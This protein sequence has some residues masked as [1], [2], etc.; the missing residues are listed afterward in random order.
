[1]EST[2]SLPILTPIE[3]RVLG[4]LIEKSK[5]TPD[6]YPMTLN[7]LTAACNQK[8]SRRPV[9]DYDEETVV[10]ALNSLKSQSLINTAVGGSIRSIKYKHNFTIV[11]PLTDGEL[12]IMCLLFLRGPQTPGELNTNS[13]R[14]HEFRSLEGLQDALNKLTEG[15][16]AFVKELPKRAGQKEARFAHLLEEEILFDEDETPE[17]P[18]RKH[19]SDLETRLA[20]VELELAEVK[21]TLAKITKDLF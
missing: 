19:V 16:N 10:M 1:M 20:A 4:S 12:A 13:A 11:Y 17:E 15:E 7:A 9:V 14:L 5:T 8:T 2:R 6:Y 21:E 3:I 18:A